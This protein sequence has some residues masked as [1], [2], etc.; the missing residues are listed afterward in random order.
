MFTKTKSFEY[1]ASKGKRP[2]IKFDK[3]K[4]QLKEKCKLVYNDLLV[5]IINY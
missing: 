5:K 2:R 3:I 1:I 4:K